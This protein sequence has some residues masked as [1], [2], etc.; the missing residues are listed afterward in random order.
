[1]YINL[2][3]FLALRNPAL[4]F[5]HFLSSEALISYKLLSLNN[6]FIPT[7][8]KLDWICFEVAPIVKQRSQSSFL[9]NLSRNFL[10]IYV[11]DTLSP[12]QV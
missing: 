2:S 10:A 5:L 11:S 4:N 8:L 7:T 3:I 6:T 12:L 9:C 1:M